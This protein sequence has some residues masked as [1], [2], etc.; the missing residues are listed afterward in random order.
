MLGQLC[1]AVQQRFHG[2]AMEG[3]PL[4]RAP[5]EHVSLGRVELVEPRRQQCLD[6]RRHD[7][8]GSTRLADEGDHLLQ[9][10][11]IPLRCYRD[12]LAELALH[13]TEHVQQPFGLCGIER[14]EENRRRVPLAAAP[15]RTALEQ[16]GSRHA[17]QEDRRIATQVG[18]V[19]DEVEEALLSPVD[20]VEHADEGP[21]LCLPLEQLAK[22]PGDLVRRGGRV[23][24]TEQSP[25]WRDEF[26]VHGQLA[27]LLDDLDHGPVGDPLPV[28]QA[29]PKHDLSLDPA[30]E[31]CSQP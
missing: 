12:L 25:E 4:D 17:E 26:L 10:E 3:S 5:L 8:L 30:E 2:A 16:F 31:R 19:L 11:R 14:L 15:V 23:R 24:L 29:A 18:D 21:R 22:S 7:D 13:G 27:E 28:G 1:V 20:V 9:V 6:R